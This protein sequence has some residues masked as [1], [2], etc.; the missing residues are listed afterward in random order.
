M[1]FRQLIHDDLGCASYLVGDEHAGVAA[2]VDPKI[3]V[4]AYLRLARF[5][6]V[7]IDHVLETH[8][9]ADHVSGHGRLQAATGATI[10]VH[11]DAAAAYEHEPFD[12][13]WELALGDVR[14]RA[15][16]TPGHRPEHTAF[17][18]T[19]TARGPE[20]WAVLTGDSLFVGDIARPDLAVEREEGA[21][22]VFGSLRSLLALP[23]ST[24]VWPGHLGGSLCGGPGMDMKVASTVTRAR[25]PSSPACAGSC[26]SC[27]TRARSGPGT[28]AA[29]CAAGR[30]WT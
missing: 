15:L 27:P 13:G 8:T 25:A 10:H 14:V 20:P 3:D 30:E 4:D 18:L 22:G 17:V 12:D 6:G 21:R 23:G 5:L 2:V 16:H 9:H 19:D 24:E 26:S 7:A 1:I 29:R 11:R 28:S